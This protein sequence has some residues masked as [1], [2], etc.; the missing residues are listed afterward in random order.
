[1]TNKDNQE[2]ILNFVSDEILYIHGDFDYTISQHVIPAFYQLIEREKNKKEGKIIIDINSCGGLTQYLHQLLG[3]VEKAKKENI[4]IETRA[5]SYAMSCG[6]ML[7]CS[8]TNG[9]RFI[10]ETTTHLC[11]L[12]SG[13][14]YA[15]NDIELERQSDF[16]KEHFNFV[17]KTYK[18][19][20]KIPDLNKI[21]KD[22]S[23][24]ITGQKIIDW[25]LAD[26]FY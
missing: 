15:K 23:L 17:R 11:H 2:K 4:I 21:I 26:K 9:H 19:Y 1:M 6:S 14:V 12:G 25:G 13:G 18:K 20:A 5:L 16:L 3:M 10:S 22:D 7:A 8:G 24:Y